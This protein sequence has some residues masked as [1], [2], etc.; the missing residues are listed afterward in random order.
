MIDAI[1]NQNPKEMRR[2]IKAD[3]SDSTKFVLELFTLHK[4]PLEHHF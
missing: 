2:W 4:K 3:L 1:R